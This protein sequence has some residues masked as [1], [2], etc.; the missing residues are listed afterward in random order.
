MRGK[1]SA[2][3]EN[4]EEGTSEGEAG[5]EGRASPLAHSLARMA[6]FS[7]TC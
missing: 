6:T 2:V 3:Y 5:Q 1:R 4:T 7:L